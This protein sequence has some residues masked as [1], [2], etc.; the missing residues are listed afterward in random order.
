[1]ASETFK[2]NCL[3]HLAGLRAEVLCDSGVSTSILFAD[4]VDV[5]IIGKQFLSDPTGQPYGKDE[6]LFLHTEGDVSITIARGERG[7]SD[8]MLPKAITP[9]GARVTIAIGEKEED[10][11][12][13]DLLRK[14]LQIER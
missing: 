5:C 11:N 14:P 2:T 13:I 12:I 7:A 3:K 1:M 6:V 8:R 4:D 9:N 10:H